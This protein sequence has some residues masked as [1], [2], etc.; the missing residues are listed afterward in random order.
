MIVLSSTITPQD[1]RKAVRKAEKRYWKIAHV[2]WM[3][4]PAIG[5][6]TREQSSLEEFL[7][8]NELF[9]GDDSNFYSY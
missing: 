1:Y 4:F 3:G 5:P 2:D 7:N 9:D 6:V 8:A